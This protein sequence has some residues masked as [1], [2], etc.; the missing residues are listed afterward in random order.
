MQNHII[1]RQILAMSKLEHT[2]ILSSSPDSIAEVEALVN[3]LINKF[4]LCPDK[5]CHILISLTEAVNNAIL[6]G[7]KADKAKQVTIRYKH[8]NGT[9]EICVKDEGPGFDPNSIPDPTTPE[10]VLK[11][12]GRGVFLIKQLADEVQFVDNG[13]AVAMKFS[14]S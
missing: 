6:H 7:N 1:L 2:I 12:G 14:I 10:N 4:H 5:S 11:L 9:L 3:K 8:L 13:S